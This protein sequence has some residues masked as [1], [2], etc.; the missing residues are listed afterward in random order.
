MALVT[1]SDTHGGGE[2]AFQRSG[3]EDG[4][5]ALSFSA[6]GA[7]VDVMVPPVF[8]RT[9]ISVRGED[10]IACIAYTA[11]GDTTNNGN[12]SSGGPPAPARSTVRVEPAMAAYYPVAGRGGGP[13]GSSTAD[14]YG[15][16]YQMDDQRNVKR[17]LLEA[18]LGAEDAVGLDYGAGRALPVP[19]PDEIAATRL[20]GTHLD[21][22]HVSS[23]PLLGRLVA[24]ALSSRT[25]PAR[26]LLG[27]VASIDISH[28]A[29]GAVGR[30]ALPELFDALGAPRRWPAGLQLAECPRRLRDGIA[31]TSLALA[32][33][34]LLLLDPSPQYYA[35][36]QLTCVGC[37]LTDHDA[38]MLAS[39]LGHRH[40]CL[41]ANVDLSL[42]DITDKGARRLLRSLRANR[43][44][45]LLLLVGN[46]GIAS[47]D[48][49]E[50][51]KRRLAQNSKRASPDS[52]SWL[53]R[54]FSRC[55]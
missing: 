50:R 41:L 52:R 26:L 25:D 46:D 45:T 2:L 40:R 47:R 24:V 48:T 32:Y 19:S 21:A 54:L 18:L 22:A 9:T 28:T 39:M 8:R 53:R 36:T 6:I 16:L 5:Q 55:A 38:A 13:V 51:I 33:V 29:L 3:A 20:Q 42:N 23:P 35:V 11:P 1:S 15:F 44:V 34:V 30:Q 37:G 43:T 10:Q 17:C 7:P 27:C 14:S 49:L 31:A 4:H 12:G